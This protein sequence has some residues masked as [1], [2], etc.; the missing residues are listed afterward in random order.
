MTTLTI[1]Q[2]RDKFADCADEVCFH[3]KSICVQRRGKPVLVM[4]SNRDYELLI[5]VKKAKSFAA[6]KKSLEKGQFIQL[7]SSLEPIHQD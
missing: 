7:D 4:I 1:S 3:G 6:T 2:V 5:E